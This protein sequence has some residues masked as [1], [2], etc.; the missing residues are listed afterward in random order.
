MGTVGVQKSKVNDFK[1]GEKKMV[2]YDSTNESLAAIVAGM[3]A[4]P[5]DRILAI[6][7]SGDQA[8]AL[9]EYSREVVAVDSDQ[10]QIAYAQKRKEALEQG[11]IRKFLGGYFHHQKNYFKAEGRLEKI[12]EKLHFLDFRH[13]DLLNILA[14]KQFTKYYFSNIFTYTSTDLSY[15]SRVAN[16]LPESALVY[17]AFKGGWRPP[18]P[19]TLIKD[20]ELTQK[21]QSLEDKTDDPWLP[22]VFRKVQ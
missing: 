3:D 9:L 15:I 13:A 18:L 5:E 10:S 14:Q 12:R 1:C 20:Q 6:C 17:I 19:A 8:F 7:G 11:N 4:Q 21:A 16:A 22:E 2:T